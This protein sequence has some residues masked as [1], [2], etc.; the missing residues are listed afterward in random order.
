[1]ITMMIT[2]SHASCC[3]ELSI[4]VAS[5]SESESA[6]MRDHDVLGARKVSTNEYHSYNP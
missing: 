3:P 1:M 5:I 4:L 6:S 2:I